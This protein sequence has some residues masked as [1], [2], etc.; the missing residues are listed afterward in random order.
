MGHIK[1]TLLLLKKCW[2][3]CRIEGHLYINFKQTVKGCSK[4]KPG[5]LHPRL[6]SMTAAFLFTGSACGKATCVPQGHTH[7][8]SHRGHLHSYKTPTD[9]A[10]LS[11]A[12]TCNASRS[13]LIGKLPS[14]SLAGKDWHSLV[15]AHAHSWIPQAPVWLLCLPSTSAP[16]PGPVTY[17]MCPPLASWSSLV[18]APNRHMYSH[19]CPTGTP[20]SW[21]PPHTIMNL[22]PIW[23]HLPGPRAYYSLAG[24]PLG[25]WVNTQAHPLHTQFLNGSSVSDCRSLA[26][27]LFIPC[28]S[29][30]V[31][32]LLF[33]T[34]FFALLSPFVLKRSLTGEN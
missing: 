33:I 1:K 2:Y 22:L 11:M 8:H 5:G 24:S 28:L 13:D 29:V 30:C 7:T 18:L 34:S 32:V 15:K 9:D 23:P 17:P 12:P 27:P 31:C 21:C 26:L 6:M 25:L 10:L 19:T 14:P 20:H 3:D 4:L 16:I